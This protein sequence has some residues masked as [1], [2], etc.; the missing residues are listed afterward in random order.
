M[1]WADVMR[2]DFLTAV[3]TIT[4]HVLKLEAHRDSLIGPRLLEL[5]VNIATFRGL[6]SVPEQLIGP[7]DENPVRELSIPGC[8]RERMCVYTIFHLQYIV[9]TNHLHTYICTH[10]PL[11]CLAECI[12]IRSLEEDAQHLHSTGE[13]GQWWACDPVVTVTPL[14]K[15]H[16]K[17]FFPLLSSPSFWCKDGMVI[18]AV[19]VK[20]L[21]KRIRNH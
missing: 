2:K 16:R 8:L 5:E 12:L 14:V 21:R 17:L 19:A 6:R 11:S 1:W 18:A 4:P 9:Y 10:T 13:L 7:H 15:F 3:G 20:T